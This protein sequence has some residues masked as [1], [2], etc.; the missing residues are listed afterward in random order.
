MVGARHR[1]DRRRVQFAHEPGQVVRADFY[2]TVGRHDDVMPGDRHH[3]NEIGN[4][5][6]GAMLARFDRDC[7]RLLG[8]RCLQ[9]PDNLKRWIGGIMAKLSPEQIQAAFGAAGYSPKQIVGF[10]KVLEGRI[11]ELSRL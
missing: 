2:I 6:I 7:D 8:K 9:V 5:A 3:V 4:L 11:A 10:S 1:P